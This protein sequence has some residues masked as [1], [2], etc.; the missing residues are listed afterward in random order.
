M[1]YTTQFRGQLEFNKKLTKGMLETYKKFQQERHEDG[2][3]PNGKPSIWLQW[4]I[5]EE[6]GKHY[7]EWDG[8]EK[9]YNYIDWIEYVIK[10][11][12]KG[13]GLELNG[14]IDWRGEEWEDNGSI[15]VKNNIVLTL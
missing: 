7:L 14:Q 8:G 12:F 4:E 15:T 9:F 6:D 5:T 3:K 2:Y 11:I 13:W 10:Y 1:G